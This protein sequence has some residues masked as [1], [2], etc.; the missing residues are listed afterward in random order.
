MVAFS[1]IYIMY[2]ENQNYNLKNGKTEG[3]YI[4]QQT[5]YLNR[6]EGLREGYSEIKFLF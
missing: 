3:K 6:Q 4:N 2:D 1:S 5:M